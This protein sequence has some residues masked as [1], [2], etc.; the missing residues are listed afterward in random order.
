MDFFTQQDRSRRQ[1][2][3]LVFLF[4]LAVVAIVAV[5]DLALVVGFGMLRPDD[6]PMGLGEV[7]RSNGPLLV[8]GSLAT[9]AVIGLASLAKTVMLRGGGGRVA[10]ELGGVRVDP[11]TRDPLKR[12]LMNVV[13]ELSLASGVPVPEVYLL[14][15]EAGINAFA[16]GY[17]TADA[18]IAVTRGTLEKLDRNELQGVI[19][20]EFSH[21]LNGDMRL[22]IRLMGVLFGILLLG[23]IGRRVLF[24]GHYVGRSRDKG[25]M[26][27][28]LLAIALMLV[29]YV[30]LFFG[31]WIKSAVS[32]QREYLADAS[33]VQFTRLP[34]GIAGALKKIAV[35]S[36][37]SHL[38]AETEEVAHMLFGPG[39]NMHLFATHPPLR[40]RIRRIEPGFSDEDLKVLAARISRAQKAAR[41]EPEPEPERQGTMFDAGKLI[42]QIGNP[43][44]HRLMTA[45]VVA[46]SLPG[47]ARDAARDE[48]RAVEALLYGLL[49]ADADLQEQ[50]LLLIAQALGP[51]T[52]SRVRHL[53]RSAGALDKIQRLA[54]LEIALPVVSRQP[55]EEIRE[56]LTLVD[57]LIRVDGTVEPFEYL[58][59]R[60]IR[61]YA[62][63]RSNPSAV[64]TTGKKSIDRRRTEVATVLAVVARFG[65]PG[66]EERAR[67]AWA[68][69]MSEA[70]SDAGEGPPEVGDWVSAL[71]AALETLDRLGADDKR[72]LVK[73]LIATVTADGSLVP[74]ELELM[75]AVCSALHVPI[76]VLT[77]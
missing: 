32:R 6:E 24:H 69:G 29:G 36:D 77:S 76:P 26:P 35:Y 72:R 7:L 15:R 54:L 62:W 27:I 60:M 11:D 64:R 56:L 51:E 13:E 66:A 31:R 58:A 25:G 57:R 20:H 12:R 23:I 8:G 48:R 43:D 38:E 68:A 70:Y 59:A 1:T 5:V 44:F 22:N 61:Q 49:H 65:N 52:E 50:Q 74:G 40:D 53:A 10:T 45:A 28:L 34:D 9:L 42:D 71:D 3:R 19:A 4:I 17:S 75:R 14:E 30:G 16:A 73:A 39:R 37:G 67:S 46:A 2:R 18:A 33:A 55:P 41:E 47:A 21:I 63:E